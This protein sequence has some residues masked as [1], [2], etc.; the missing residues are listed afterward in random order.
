MNDKETD[1]ALSRDF[2]GHFLRL[3][4][5]ADVGKTLGNGVEYAASFDAVNQIGRAHV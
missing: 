3:R 4:S 5:S 1:M 2:H